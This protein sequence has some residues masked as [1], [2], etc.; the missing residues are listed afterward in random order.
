MIGL[1]VI[2]RLYALD[3]SSHGEDEEHEKVHDKNRPVH[4][5]VECLRECTEQSNDGSACCGQP[6][7]DSVAEYCA[8]RFTGRDAPELPFG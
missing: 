5:H 6:K 2:I 8:S 7:K 1:C 3:L 4:G